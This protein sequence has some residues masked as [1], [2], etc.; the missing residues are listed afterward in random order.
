MEYETG[1]RESE[2]PLE[3]FLADRHYYALHRAGQRRPQK[4]YRRSL[5]KWII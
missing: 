2:L 3:S 4:V 5:K 1:S